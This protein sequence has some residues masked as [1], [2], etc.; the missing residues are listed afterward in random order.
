MSLFK[1]DKNKLDNKTMKNGA[2]L[3]VETMPSS[4]VAEQFRTIRTNIS[5]S[6]AGNKGKDIAI[7]SANPSEGKSVFSVNLATTFAKQGEKTLFI[8]ADLRRPTAHRTFNVSNS[9]GLSNLLIGTCSL[10]DAIKHTEIDNLDV[11]TCGPV[12]PNPAELLGD[13][14]FK[15]LLNKLNEKYDRVFIDTPPVNAATDA[16]L[17]ATACFGVILIVPQGYADK[18]SVRN[19]IQQLNKVHA[20]ILGFV[21]NRVSAKNTSSYGGYYGGYYGVDDKNA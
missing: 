19:A 7:T 4:P 11:I 6:V 2:P 18:N 20:K 16:S 8:D 15:D 10:D 17:I 3:I 14:A 12:P 9:E 13:E 5:F 1:K 21:M